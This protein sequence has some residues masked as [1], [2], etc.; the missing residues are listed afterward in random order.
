MATTSTQLNEVFVKSLP[1]NACSTHIFDNK[2]YVACEDHLVVMS[3][4]DESNASNT[5]QD[6]SRVDYKGDPN[7]L[8]NLDSSN[9]CYAKYNLR[10]LL[11]LDEQ[12]GILSSDF[13]CVG[14]AMLNHQNC[15]V[16]AYALT[17]LNH[18]DESNTPSSVNSNTNNRINCDSHL[19]IHIHRTVAQSTDAEL[20]Y[21][22]QSNRWSSR[23]ISSGRQAIQSFP[24][25]QQRPIS[26][27]FCSMK[28]RKD[29]GINKDEMCVNF[30]VIFLSC[31]S[32]DSA[33]T[34]TDSKIRCFISINEETIADGKPTE[35]K[36][37]EISFKEGTIFCKQGIYKVD[38]SDLFASLVNDISSPV[39]SIG[40]V[41]ATNDNERTGKYISFSTQDGQVQ[42]F[43]LGIAFDGND[44]I[45]SST[46]FHFNVQRMHSFVIDG[47][48]LSLNISYFSRL[49]LLAGNL[50]GYVAFFQVDDNGRK[51]VGPCIV[52][53]THLDKDFIS[54]I[55][56]GI[57][58]ITTVSQRIIKT[59]HY[60]SVGTYEG[61]VYLY[62]MKEN[63][64]CSKD[65]CS[66]LFD[67]IWSRLL[68]QPV[69]SI[70]IFDN[71]T[72]LI[73]TNSTMH[74][75][76][77]EAHRKADLAKSKFFRMIQD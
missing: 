71:E 3:I 6:T 1:S 31:L 40:V 35:I 73:V 41:Q 70:E 77:N 66:P 24:L 47:P 25:H 2:V 58:S 8:S 75:V 43:E 72:L 22:K 65:D 68:L 16:H 7:I 67:L 5:C 48:S 4:K 69:R 44:D 60:I 57:D 59:S 49:S 46:Q 63:V 55:N 20:L 32:M 36:F 74:I 30:D 61:R 11:K 33:S 76:R 9:C 27:S 10:S 29:N 45:S 21:Q 13:K 19:I 34:R 50:L 56:D 39:L 42:M 38:V 37:E 26:I 53:K 18:G 15:F 14:H 28:F 23:F 52:M 64:T 51:I 54:E 62:K 17:L 12:E